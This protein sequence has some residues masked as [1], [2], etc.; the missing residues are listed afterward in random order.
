MNY[1]K[2]SQGELEISSICLGC[3][4]IV[5]DT[6]WGSQDLDNSIATIQRALDLGINFLD[7]AEAY[8]DGLSERL[9]AKALTGRKRE[10]V[11]IATKVLPQNLKKERLIRSCEASLHRLNTDYIDVYYIHWPN[12]SIPLEETIETMERLKSQGKI[13]YIGVSNFGKKDLSEMV[14]LVKPVINQLPYSL[15]WR[16]IEFEILPTCKKYEVPVAC[17]SPLMQGLLT[18]K[19]RS[20]DEVPV[21]R[22]RTRLFR[23][24]RPMSRHGEKGA[25]V[26][27][28]AAINKIREISEDVGVSMT[29][30]S[31][32][33]L[34]EQ[35]CVA[36]VVVGARSPEQVE[37]IVKGSDIK[38]SKEIISRLNKATE[39]IKTLMGNNPDMW[40]SESRFR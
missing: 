15:L 32:A 12:R 24:N 6:T 20:A 33:W 3:W 40:Q 2:I 27:T 22:A 13:R 1:R 8:G 18:G 9:I 21:G 37:E 28:F 38:L 7:T 36:C 17:Y 30:L 34:L 29:Q 26:E 19:F 23:G 5:G 35:E 25:E 39:L 31:L 14:R 16:A 4:A 11:V 10:D